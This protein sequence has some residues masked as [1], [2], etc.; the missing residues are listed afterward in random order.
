MPEIH[1]SSDLSVRPSNEGDGT[2]EGVGALT[3][4]RCRANIS[5]WEPGNSLIHGEYGPTAVGKRGRS[6]TNKKPR[7]LIRAGNF[8]APEHYHQ[9]EPC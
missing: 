4:H 5:R 9:S 8:A 1:A 3:A 7:P 2:S 6:C